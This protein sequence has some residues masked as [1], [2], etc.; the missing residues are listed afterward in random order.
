VENAERGRITHSF[1]V[2]LWREEL[3]AGDVEWRGRIQC[4][5]SGEARHVRGLPALL[6]ALGEL[7]PPDDPYTSQG[8]GE[9]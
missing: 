6:A 8:V 7:L 9:A 2:R 4:L 1:L 5:R 3:G